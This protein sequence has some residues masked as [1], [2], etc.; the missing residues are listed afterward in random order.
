MDLTFYHRISKVASFA[1]IPYLII[2]V[3][4]IPYFVHQ[5]ILISQRIKNIPAT[6]IFSIDLSK[7]KKNLKIQSLIYNFI[8]IISSFEALCSLLVT[9]GSIWNSFDY[10]LV[11]PLNRRVVNTNTNKSCTFR[12]QTGTFTLIQASESLVFLLPIGVGNG[13]AG[14]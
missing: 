1:L 4:T 10:R 7:V 13:P 12:Y 6:T 8:I 2:T 9:V 3:F 11:D 5:K 14:P